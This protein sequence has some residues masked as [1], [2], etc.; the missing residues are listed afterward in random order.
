MQQLHNANY[1]NEKIKSIKRH[2]GIEHLEMYKYLIQYS[3]TAL[4]HSY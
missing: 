2:T 1:L 3:I 4:D